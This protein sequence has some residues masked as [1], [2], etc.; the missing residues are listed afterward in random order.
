MAHTSLDSVMRHV[1]SLAAGQGGKDRT[2][3]QLLRAFSAAN[4]QDAFAVLARRHGPLV[5]AV[6][7][8]V[9][10]QL[11]DAE[12]A[13]Q[14]TF[15][16]LAPHAATVGHRESISGWLHGVAYRMA[17]NARK[18]AARRRRHERKFQA[19]K[20]TSPEWEAAWHEVQLLLDEEVQRLAE[21]YREPFVLC[22]L[23]GQSCA[24]V[25]RQLGLKE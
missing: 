4:D 15:L 1:R 17:L 6:C 19:M 14:A 21:K 24:Q 9:L 7:R 22:C 16:L 11:Q 25:A 10:G 18:A 3:G 23:S 13:F 20:S 12:D 5:L 8:R 2:D